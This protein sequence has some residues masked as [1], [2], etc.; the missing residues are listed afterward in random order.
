MPLSLAPVAILPPIMMAACRLVPHAC[1]SVVPGVAGD[2]LEPSTASRAR[3]QSRE[4]DTTAPPTASSISAPFRSNLSTRPFSVAV[5][6][7]RLE[8]SAYSVLE[9]QN[10]MR[11]PPITATRRSS[12]VMWFSD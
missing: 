8:L 7:S 4:C 2:S 9:R 1:T 5:S 11:E 12:W 10:G 3:F 6:I